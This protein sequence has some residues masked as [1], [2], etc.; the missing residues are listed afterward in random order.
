MSPQLQFGEDDLIVRGN[1]KAA[2]QARNES[3]TLDLWFEVF[4]QFRCQAHGPVSVVSNR[5]IFDPDVHHL[6]LQ[7]NYKNYTS[8]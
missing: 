4:Q 1:F 8:S 5:A 2:S 6:L 3:E 7:S